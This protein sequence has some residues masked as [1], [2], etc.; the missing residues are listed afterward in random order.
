VSKLQADNQALRT[1]M[2]ATD[3]YKSAQSIIE[4]QAAKSS[5]GK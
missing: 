1:E 4:R 2:I 3:R 5:K